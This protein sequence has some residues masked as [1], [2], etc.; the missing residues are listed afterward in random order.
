MADILIA[1]DTEEG[2]TAAVSRQVAEGFRERG[3]AVDLVEL[4]R[5]DP[6]V[7]GTDAVIVGG[8][9][10]YGQHGRALRS[11]LE[12]NREQLQGRPTAFFQL[13]MSSAVD[14]RVRRSEAAAYV[15]ELL[16]QTGF[17]PDRIAKFGG[18]LR[19]SKYGFLKRLMMKRIA[20]KATGDTDIRR[21]YEYTDWDEVD[22]FA[23]DVAAF[24][25]GRVRAARPDPESA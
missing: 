22:A 25:E 6:A 11:F 16:E 20:R 18:A 9:V 21:D 17:E 24:V 7:D 19:Y 3:H 13:S 15:D 4:G 10:H 1:Y 5:S 14:D 12:S 2:Q 8:S 23:A